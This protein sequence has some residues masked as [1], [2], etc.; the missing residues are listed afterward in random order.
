MVQPVTVK[1][2]YNI[3]PRNATFS[4]GGVYKCLAKSNLV[5]EA[6]DVEGI[7]IQEDPGTNCIDR[8][9]YKHCD[10]VYLRHWEDPLD[11]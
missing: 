6:F 11:T 3:G 2:S 9:S 5:P 1:K 4:D 7:Q 8:P 10:K